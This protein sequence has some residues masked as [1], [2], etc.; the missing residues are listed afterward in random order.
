MIVN[1]YFIIL[2][3]VASRWLP[4]LCACVNIYGEMIGIILTVSLH[5]RTE[6]DSSLFAFMTALSSAYEHR[7]SVGGVPIW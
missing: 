6:G 3:V 2:R 4:H 5:L 7:T 1:P